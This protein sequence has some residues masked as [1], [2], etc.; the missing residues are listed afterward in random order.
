M[1]VSAYDCLAF[2]DLVSKVKLRL[3]RIDLPISFRDIVHHATTITIMVV[4]HMMLGELFC[5]IELRK[6]Y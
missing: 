6:G 3:S 5:C 1:F 2:D 4:N